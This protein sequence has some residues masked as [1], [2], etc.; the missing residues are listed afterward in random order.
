M[1]VVCACVHGC[2]GAR[3]YVR[4]CMCVWVCVCMCMRTCVRACVCVCVCVSVPVCGHT[5]TCTMYL[6]YINDN[7]W[8]IQILLFVT[9]SWSACVQCMKTLEWRVAVGMIWE[10]SYTP[11]IITS[12]MYWRMGE[13]WP[14][15]YI[16]IC[17]N[18]SAN[19]FCYHS[20]YCGASFGTSVVL[21]C[22]H[23]YNIYYVYIMWHVKFDNHKIF[24]LKL[25]I[26]KL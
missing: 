2:V 9:R 20:V 14:L 25:C 6:I 15:L 13:C 11:L 3:V 26:V 24:K 22:Y 23:T 8:F 18:Y 1:F 19:H 5:Y 4:D 10:C 21:F 16:C 7:L 17:V 12:N